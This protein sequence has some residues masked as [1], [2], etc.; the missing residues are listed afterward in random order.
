A[1]RWSARRVS[2]EMRI[3]GAPGKRPGEASRPQAAARSAAAMTVPRSVPRRLII[4]RT[5]RESFRASRRAEDHI[6]DAIHRRSEEVVVP[7]REHDDR[8]PLV[9]V[10]G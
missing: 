1:G 2:T 5:R 8:E 9:R 3:T 6:G 7:V 4:D 10:A